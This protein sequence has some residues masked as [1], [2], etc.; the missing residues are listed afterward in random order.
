MLSIVVQSFLLVKS[1]D[2]RIEGLYSNF[3]H[4][5]VDDFV[6]RR[7]KRNDDIYS[8]IQ[9]DVTQTMCCSISDVC[10]ARKFVDEFLSDIL[11]ELKQDAIA[12]KMHFLNQ[13]R[14]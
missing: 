4:V 2:E 7:L 3:S 13:D 5:S 6:L 8:F 10:K 12:M 11:S 14:R 1:D 9:T